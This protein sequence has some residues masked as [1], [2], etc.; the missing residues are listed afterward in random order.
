MSLCLSPSRS[1][2]STVLVVGR[3]DQ[4]TEY[5]L[6][7]GTI[8]KQEKNVSERRDNRRNENSPKLTDIIFLYQLPTVS[9][10]R[11]QLPS[12]TGNKDQEQSDQDW[13][14]YWG[15]V[16]HNQERSD[17][18]DPPSPDDPDPPGEPV[19]VK[20]ILILVSDTAWLSR[21]GVLFCFTSDGAHHTATTDVGHVL[22]YQGVTMGGVAH[23]V[24]HT[25]LWL[26]LGFS[27]DEWIQLDDN[28]DHLLEGDLDGT[29]DHVAE[30]FKQALTDEITEYWRDD[31]HPGQKMGS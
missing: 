10:S 30:L 1:A 21:E 15:T 3:S 18:G 31:R 24:G 14:H 8:L 19:T 5:K 16:T 7:D 29:H 11:H 13:Q 28:G 20:H 9:R 6:S 17:N 2:V 23:G 27:A 26:Y 25:M 22:F 12:D 4:L